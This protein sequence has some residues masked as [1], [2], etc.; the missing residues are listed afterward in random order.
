MSAQVV[1]LA[2]P[3]GSGKSRLCR[4]LGLPF[5]NLDDFY[6]DGDAPDLPRVM[7]AGDEEIVDWDDPASV[8]GRLCPSGWLLYTADAADD[9]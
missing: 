3:S 2:G 8:S 6:K 7:L 9:S 4:R 1:V 5:V